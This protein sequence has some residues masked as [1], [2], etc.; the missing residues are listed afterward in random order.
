MH[1]TALEPKACDQARVD[2]VMAELE[3]DIACSR[4]TY[5]IY[6]DEQKALFLYLLRFKFLKVKPAAERAA[7]NP[8]TAQ[9]WVKR[10]NED[11]EWNI[12][13]KLTNKVN[14][15]GSQLQDEHKHFLI[16]LFDEEPQATRKDA[17]DALT[18]EFEGFNLKESQVGT[19]IRNECNLT[20]KRITRHPMARNSPDTLLKRKVWVEKWSQTDMDYLSNCVFVDESAFDIN[21]RPSTARSEK[22]TP[23][24][25]TTPSTRAVSHT[26]LGAVSAMGVV[27]IEIRLPNQKPKRIKVDGA[28]KRKQPQPKKATSKGTVTG[29]YMLFLQN[30]MNFM[31]QFP[32]MKGFYIVMDNAPIHTAD[33]IDQMVTKRGYKS[34]YLPPYSPE[35]NP[36]ENFWSTM[37]SYVKRSKFSSDEDLKIRVAEASN[38]VSAT[39]LLNMSQHSVN[40]FD[41]C[42][43]MEPI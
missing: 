21:M 29:Y 22:G 1:Q 40:M 5:N 2:V 26:I 23:A 8:R 12:Y 14:R 33:D 24:V 3:A 18:A 31:D 39:A 35:L 19:F 4:K 38:G 7:I 16:N 36:I 11:P 9:G 17:V 27:N 28:R 34:I 43:R 20:V 41:K 25:V 6:T 13:G 15:A 10:M 42:L 30:T 32:E 37:K